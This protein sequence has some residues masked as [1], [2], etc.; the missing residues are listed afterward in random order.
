MKAE[1]ASLSRCDLRF[2]FGS[3]GQLSQQIRNGAP[4]DLFLSAS[5]AFV[6]NLKTLDKRVYAH[7]RLALWSRSGTVSWSDLAT[8]KVGRIAIAN[9]KLAP[10]GLAARQALESQGL[11]PKVESKIVYAENVRQAYQ[12]TESGN[13]D[14]CLVSMS[15]VAGKNGFALQSS[16]H[17]PIEQTAALLRDSPDA[18]KLFDYLT[19][20]RGRDFFRR[21]GLE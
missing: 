1:L 2:T 18:R 6:N 17:Q 4:Y 5:P 13:A 8:S 15:L 12:F 10:Y 7:G 14:V 11:W 21:H 20:P 16:W 3:S 9:P 19:G